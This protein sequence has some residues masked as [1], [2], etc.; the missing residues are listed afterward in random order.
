MPCYQ[1]DGVTPVVHP[2]AYVHPTAV[3]IGDVHVGANCYVG[4]CASLRGD[5]GRIVMEAGSNLQ[6]SCVVHAFPGRDAI[7]RRNGHVGHGAI[8]HG[9]SIEEDAMVGMN[10]VIMDEAVIAARSIVGACAFV[11]AGFECEPASLIVG[12]PAKVLRQL[13]DKEVGWKQSGTRE[14]QVLTER[15]LETIKECAPLTE[16]DESRPQLRVGSH[17][18]KD[19]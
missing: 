7:V 17:S 15:C 4:P 11:K 9:C 6:D 18:L 12:S 19:R 5:F 14:Y 2:S 1:I 3:L 13:N 10:S 8:L 16:I